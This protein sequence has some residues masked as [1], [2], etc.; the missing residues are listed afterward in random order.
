MKFPISSFERSDL[1]YLSEFA[2]E[3]NKFEA[4]DDIQFVLKK[5]EIY[6]YI[7][8]FIYLYIFI[9]YILYYILYTIILYN[10]TL[11]NIMQNFAYLISINRETKLIRGFSY[12]YYVINY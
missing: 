9:Y 1:D 11:Y 8:I 2:I 3:R 12:S 7:Y 5:L 6:I 4:D 10:I